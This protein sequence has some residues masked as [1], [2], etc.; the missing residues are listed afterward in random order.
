MKVCLQILKATNQ[1]VVDVLGMKNTAL[2]PG[3]NA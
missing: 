1:M 2:V 3:G